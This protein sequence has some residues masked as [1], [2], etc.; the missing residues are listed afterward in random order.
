MGELGVV[1]RAYLDGIDGPQAPALRQEG[2]TEIST[3][4]PST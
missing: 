1:R 2:T 4:W 3:A